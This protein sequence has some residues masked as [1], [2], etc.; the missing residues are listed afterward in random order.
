M[1]TIT[2]AFQRA[3][4]SFWDRVISWW[5]RSPYFHVAVVLPDGCL[6]ESLPGLGVH[7]VWNQT[8]PIS[9]WD[10]VALIV[11]DEALVKGR[12][13]LESELGC[14]YDWFGLLWAQILGLP[15]A[16]SQKWFCSELTA[17]FM[18]AM[19]MP[20]RHRPAWYSPHRFFDAVPR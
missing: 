17:A 8:L 16:D 20:M 13:F 4:R 14:R 12:D 18:N 15:W 19:A 6:Y 1:P 5:T 7:K 9:D 3:P 2:F 10:L 11:S